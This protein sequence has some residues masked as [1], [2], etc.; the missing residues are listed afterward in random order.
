M[1]SR[2]KIHNVKFLRNLDKNG[3]YSPEL[4]VEK[5]YWREGFLK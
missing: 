3:T 1:I 5:K 4:V 2:K